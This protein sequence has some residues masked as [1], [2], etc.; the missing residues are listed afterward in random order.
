[1]WYGCRATIPSSFV[2]DWLGLFDL[3]SLVSP[4]SRHLASIVRRTCRVRSDD[5]DRLRKAANWMHSSEGG[6]VVVSKL[7]SSTVH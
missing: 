2:P 4:C 7:A 6:R 1:M 3:P 5:E